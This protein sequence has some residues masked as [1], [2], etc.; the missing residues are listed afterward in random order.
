MIDCPPVIELNHQSF[1]LTWTLCS[2]LKVLPNYMI[3]PLATSPH[4]DAL[5]E[6]L[7]TSFLIKHMETSHQGF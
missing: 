1:L 3:G 4:L 7:A 5:Q 2:K 6:L